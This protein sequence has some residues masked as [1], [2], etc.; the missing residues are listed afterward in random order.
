[1]CISDLHYFHY[2]CVRN[3]YGNNLRLLVTKS[4]SLIY[5]INTK[6]ICEYFSKNKRCLLLVIIHQF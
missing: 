1:M 5:E 4:D 2:D 3:K 6:N